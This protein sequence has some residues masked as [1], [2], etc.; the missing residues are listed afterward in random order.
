MNWWVLLQLTG[1]WMQPGS[2]RK[3]DWHMHIVNFSLGWRTWLWMMSFHLVYQHRAPQELLSPHPPPP[4]LATAPQGHH[5]CWHFP[6]CHLGSVPSLTLHLV[7]CLH[8][9]VKHY[10]WLVA[11][12][13]TPVFSEIWGWVGRT[14]IL[15]LLVCLGNFWPNRHPNWNHSS[16]QDT[17]SEALSVKVFP[18]HGISKSQVFQISRV[19]LAPV[20]SKASLFS[21]LSNSVSSPKSFQSTAP[22]SEQESFCVLWKQRTVTNILNNLTSVEIPN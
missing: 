17:V 12:S 19:A 20:F 2:M 18:F 22:S 5:F 11:L 14:S 13:V 6:L 10:I 9:V 16:P 7:S 8:I 3:L 15:S 4:S 21:S 1:T